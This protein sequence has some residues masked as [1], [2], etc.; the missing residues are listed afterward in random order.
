M[1][2]APDEKGIPHTTMR[3]G[4]L[5]GYSVFTF[6]GQKYDIEFHAPAGRPTIK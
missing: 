2:P 5:N 1:E 4:A 3:D 6:D